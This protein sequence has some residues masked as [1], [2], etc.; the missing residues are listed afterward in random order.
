M[1]EPMTRYSLFLLLAVAACSSERP[2]A[3]EETAT[4]TAGHAAPSNEAR[5]IVT[6][7]GFNNPESVRYDPDLNLWFVANMNGNPTARDNN[8]YISRIKSDG[9]T[10]SLKFI[11][12]GKGGVTLNAPKGM[13]IV[14]DTL[15]V[16]DLDAARAF[17][18]RTGA[19]VA[20]VS[21]AKRAKFLN[22]MTVGPDGIYMTD[23]GLEGPKLD[24]KGPDQIFKIAGRKATVVLTLKNLAAPN[25]I[26]WDSASS[27][28][29]IAPFGAPTVVT[30]APGDSAPTP[31][32]EGK[33]QFDGIEP[34]GNQRYLLTSWT[35]STL[36][37]V[38]N[39]Q[40]TRLAGEIPS[41]ADIG[42]DRKRGRVAVPEL[43]E[44][45]IVFLDLPPGTQ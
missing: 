3:R 40:I 6:A 4:A 23:S 39:G 45:R 17:N 5:R 35:D 41:P 24:H 29:V 30:W 14:G 13:A 36:N 43:M 20:T 8:G 16:A 18:K 15:W 32:A 33:G 10:D 11:Q 25:G 21:L 19:P 42:F 12:G 44:G 26:T 31:L 7:T 1:P 27:R 28:F 9:S 38:A 2:A 22:D 37:L 34:L